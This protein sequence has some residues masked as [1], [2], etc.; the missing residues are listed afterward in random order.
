MLL[1][2]VFCR[3]HFYVLFYNT[4]KV[5]EPLQIS[6]FHKLLMCV[7]TKLLLRFRF[8]ERQQRPVK[9]SSCPAGRNLWLR[10][11]LSSPYKS[12]IQHL[13]IYSMRSTKLLTLLTGEPNTICWHWYCSKAYVKIALRL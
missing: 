10:W 3:I 5:K 1:S 8:P 2:I 11:R 9:C 12:V 6:N 7:I 4:I 13:S